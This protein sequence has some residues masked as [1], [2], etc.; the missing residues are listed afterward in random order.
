MTSFTVRLQKKLSVRHWQ[1]G[2]TFQK[3]DQL[4]TDLSK[5]NCLMNTITMNCETRRVGEYSPAAWK[6]PQR[7]GSTIEAFRASA[8]ASRLVSLFLPQ[9][10]NLISEC[11]SIIWGSN[12]IEDWWKWLWNATK[13]LKQFIENVPINTAKA[14]CI[15]PISCYFRRECFDNLLTYNRYGRNTRLETSYVS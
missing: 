10:H 13:R 7:F 11:L 15:L 9:S 8:T 14:T 3:S 6:P 4:V 12:T 5:T 1:D 2:P